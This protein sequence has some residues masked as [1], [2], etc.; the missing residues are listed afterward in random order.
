MVV[1]YLRRVILNW[2]RLMLDLDQ[3]SQEAIDRIAAHLRIL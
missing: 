2:R 1:L 3:D